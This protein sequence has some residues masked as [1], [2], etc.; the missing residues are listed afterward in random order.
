MSILTCHIHCDTG[1]ETSY[2]NDEYHQIRK[3]DLE[4]KSKDLNEMTFRE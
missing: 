2:E 3:Y 4:L 1:F